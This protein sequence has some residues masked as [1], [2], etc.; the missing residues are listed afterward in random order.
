[1]VKAVAVK[2]SA[3]G[4]EARHPARQRRPSPPLGWPREPREAQSQSLTLA[5]SLP[6]SRVHTFHRDETHRSSSIPPCGLAG[7]RM[8]TGPGETPKATARA[9]SSHMVVGGMPAEEAGGLTAEDGGLAAVAELPLKQI[10]GVSAGADLDGRGI[11]T[12]EPAGVE[13][14]TTSRPIPRDSCTLLVGYRACGAETAAL[15]EEEERDLG[16]GSEKETRVAT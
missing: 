8:G 10:C 2:P 6:L 4:P 14:L 15:G 7:G 13:P 1:M 9:P 16:A 11:P 3:V 5:A 12:E